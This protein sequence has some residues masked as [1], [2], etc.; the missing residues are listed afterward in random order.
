MKGPRLPPLEVGTV[1]EAL[2]HAASHSSAVTLVDGAENETAVG[3]DEVYSRARRCAQALCE[4]GIEPGHSVAIILP[5]ELDFLDAFFGS[6]LAGAVPVP[7]YPPMRLS[8]LDEYIKTTVSMLEAAQ[9]RVLLTDRRM[10]LLLGNVVGRARPPLGCRLVS[11]L[12]KNRTESERSV[13]PGSLGLIQFSS[14]T[15]VDPKPVAL[16]H[17]ALIAQCAALKSLLR[18]EPG[19][20]ELGVS[21]LPLYH[22]MGLIGCLLEAAYFPGPLVL[23]PPE[24]FLG[25][26]A[27]WL[28]L[29][30][31]HR[32]TISPAPSFAFGL[33]VKRIRDEELKGIDLSHWTYALN[34]AETVSPEVMERFIERFAPWGFR[35]ASMM[36]VYGLSE[37]GLAVTFS[38]RG[39]LRRIA[40]D[41]AVL[42]R[43][44]QVAAG[45]S[46]LVSVGIPVPGAEVEV[47]DDNGAQVD[48]GRVGTLWVKAPFLMKEY[49]RRPLETKQALHKGWL[50]TGD[51]GFLSEGAFYIC[52]RDKDVVIIR[53]VN[54]APQEFE[55]CLDAA[56]GVRPG[57]AVAFGFI[58]ED[59]GE[60]SLLLLVET[61]PAA[62][63]DLSERI[64][65]LVLAQTSVKPHTVRLLP[66]GTLPRTSSGKL[67]RAEALRRYLD[68]SLAPPQPVRPLKLGAAIAKSAL[69]YR[70]RG[71]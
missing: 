37:A 38:P 15:T 63:D 48:E 55:G 58:P 40:V 65:A 18:Q 41:M 52:G 47:R 17:R 27:L 22:D 44:R 69:A 50:N 31:K 39:G 26:P 23:L 25:R 62:A 46:Q 2:A 20:R 61:T 35:A 68:G 42:A 29:L 21:W 30:S 9:A 56:P 16:T 49:F 3:W 66:P 53:G 60:E 7:L 32:G 1:A 13:A 71:K 34:G 5:T 64:R 28:K 19:T 12:M 14:G 54:H 33:C 67:R 24:A 11:R 70:R 10:K 51:L 6:I 45:K 59:T 43:E 36:P 57:C 4:L 8:R